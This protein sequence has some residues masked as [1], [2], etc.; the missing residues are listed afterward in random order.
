MDKT[1]SLENKNLTKS[2]KVRKSKSGSKEVSK[3][4]SPKLS[5]KSKK[6]KS[7]KKPTIKTE[8]RKTTKR[9]QVV[10][11]RVDTVEKPN[12]ENNLD[13]MKLK[14]DKVFK[15]YGDL[16]DNN[17][18]D[19]RK[20]TVKI[21]TLPEFFWSKFGDFCDED[22]KTQTLQYIQEKAKDEKFK[23]TVFLLGTIMTQDQPESIK[24]LE[25][26]DIETIQEAF[27]DVLGLEDKALEKAY[28]AATSLKEENYDKADSKERMLLASVGKALGEL[29]KNDNSD[30]DRSVLL[31]KAISDVKE[32]LQNEEAFQN[33]LFLLSSKCKV[34]DS[35]LEAFVSAM[36]EPDEQKAKKEL[37]KFM[38]PFLTNDQIN[39]MKTE[40][41]E[42]LKKLFLKGGKK[43]KNVKSLLKFYRTTV[44]PFS[45]ED[46]ARQFHFKACKR[47]SIK[48]SIGDKS[49]AFKTV[50]N[51]AI[52]L[53]GGPE[54]KMKLVPKA[55]M[56][57][58]DLK[59]YN[60]QSH[61][62][63]RFN[64][65]L[66]EDF[67]HHLA[68]SQKTKTNPSDSKKQVLDKTKKS[69]LKPQDYLF[70]SQKNEVTI[71]VG[72][73]LDYSSGFYHDFVDKNLS[74]E[75]KPDLLTVS[76]GGVKKESM[77]SKFGMGLQ[78]VSVNDG[79]SG[80]T[81]YKPKDKDGGGL[82]DPFSVVVDRQKDGFVMKD[83]NTMEQNTM[84][85]KLPIGK[86][87]H[88]SVEIG[89]PQHLTR[90]KE[91]DIDS[92]DDD[93][94]KGLIDQLEKEMKDIQDKMK[95][96]KEQMDHLEK[97]KKA[98][99][100]NESD[101]LKRLNE[102]EQVLALNGDVK[103][104]DTSTAKSKITEKIHDLNCN[105][106]GPLERNLESLTKRYNK[107]VKQ[108]QR[109]SLFF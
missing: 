9:M 41:L 24:P 15:A 12:L 54:G 31:Q 39:G 102:D 85:Q 103:Y 55:S 53:E 27:K 56:S 105:G 29:L 94:N 43:V 59:I 72:I 4:K 21:F 36:N 82:L 61:E 5:K 11:F 104:H 79:Y 71:G 58:I 40:D 65:R 33:S 68:Q 81:F 19:Q 50:S 18:V 51:Q 69:G 108:E 6:R 100:L 91:S 101:I 92:F 86:M 7:P 1:P 95:P 84:G 67:P 64:R 48:M 106:M 49:T 74:K 13:N 16:M 77:K 22:L 83:M 30:T 88:Y 2:K 32:C 38:K 26:S 25:S 99:T 42:G 46:K 37:K 14:A 109:K 63:E 89:M 60:D 10:Q 76:S 66:K 80:D 78:G 98:I 107:L 87:E 52:V 90:S 47:A 20:G 97:F 34:K 75:Q 57:E 28:E 17:M 73:C 96:V 93:T 23:N 35:H 70:Q 44:A 8:I 45:M 62:G 3:D